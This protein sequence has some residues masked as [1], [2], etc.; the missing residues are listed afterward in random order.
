MI[1]LALA[2]VVALQVQVKVST[3]R[4][5]A[6]GRGTSIGV[7][8]GAGAQGD[9]IRRIPVTEQ[10]LATAFKSDEARALLTRARRARFTMDTA[11]KSY[12]AKAYQRI[13]LGVGVRETG[14]ERLA[15]R[16]EAV[17]R[18]QF[19]RGRGAYVDLLGKRTTSGFD[20]GQPA[21]RSRP[22]RA[23]SDSSTPPREDLPGQ[24]VPIPYFP[25]SDDLWIG[26][27]IARVQVDDRQIV[28]PL[29]VGSEAYYQ[30]AIGDSITITLPDD[31]RIVVREL[32]ITAREPRWNL[33]VGSFWFDQ[34][35]ARLVRAAYRLSVDLDVW[36]LAERDGDANDVPI[37]VKGMLSPLKGGLQLITIDYSLFDGRFWLPTVRAAEGRAQA[38][39]IRA[40]VVFEERFIYESVNEP[41]MVG[42]LIDSVL[43]RPNV[44][45]LRDSLNA[46]G[47]TG[48]ARD[49]IVALRLRTP[50]DSARAVRTAVCT[51]PKAGS[52]IPSGRYG[53]VLPVVV[54][55]PCDLA[56]LAT[57]K[58]LPASPYDS[59]EELFGVA[60]REELRQALDFDL[61]AGW[62]PQPITT[63]FGLR[64]TRYNR[65]EGFSTG[66]R[67]RQELG[68]G[69]AWESTLR[70]SLGDR[71]LNGELRGQRTTGTSTWSAGV[72][73]QLVS[74]NDWGTPLTFGASFA[75]A[76]YA[77]DEGVYHRA[78]GGD[79]QWR[80]E[81]KGRTTVRLFAEQ[82]WSA[83]VTTRWSLFRGNGD[84]RFIENL[85]ADRGTYVGAA[86]R[87][88][89]SFGLAPRGWRLDSDLRLEGAGGDG[90]YGRGALDLAVSHGL[91]FDLI[92]SLS[93]AAGSSVGDV[94]PQ[95]LWYLGGLQTVRGQTAATVAGDA[96]W[97][98]RS[99]IARGTAFRTSL[100]A[101][102]GWAGARDAIAETGRPLSGVGVGFGALDGLIRLDV[103]RGLYP[104]EQWRVDLSLGARF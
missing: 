19:E 31:R 96:F 39:F 36:E 68:Q 46:A 32:R 24:E 10:H 99:E 3:T 95:R 4:D 73:R 15:V 77:R 23:R 40:P 1:V 18:I 22:A 64:Q 93:G 67:L 69:F 65:V 82:Q 57:S 104:R 52:L 94:P 90:E 37:L 83:P 5:S 66:L 63:E 79:V 44:R 12:D 75:N 60:G 56:S 80:R 59:G 101:D 17:G 91:P 47:V 50:M 97:M 30:Y 48:P 49:S 86:L 71:Q 98:V 28:H 85:V 42:A 102:L 29:A 25:G 89:R 100:F 13:S 35:S 2:A 38:S 43:R 103:A 16:D 51:D 6:S 87:W 76:L 58:E 11:L 78:W 21:E 62:G 20:D 8:V 34:S 41:V 27:S 9:S 53:S 33:I 81:R 70:G 26:G 7:Q 55:I 72:Y 92:G 45:E 74:S 84:D 54:R 88:Q 14:R 61:Q